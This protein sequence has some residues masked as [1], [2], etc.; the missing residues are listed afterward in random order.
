[1]LDKN[2]LTIV[3][4][5]QI[6]DIPQYLKNFD[7]VFPV[8]HGNNGE[9]GKLQGFLDL[10]GIKYVGSNCLSSALCMDKGFSKILFDYLKIPQLPYRIIDYK[11]KLKDILFPVIVKPC[12]SGSSIGINKASNYK[13]LK[14]A[15][16][17]A[18]KY[19]KKI[20]IE[21]YLRVRELEYSK[22]TTNSPS[23][24][25]EVIP[26]KDYY[27][28]EAKYHS[29]SKII[30]PAILPKKIEKK[31]KE[32]ADKIFSFFECKDL[33]RIDFFLVDDTLYINEI[34]T[35]P[36]FT[37][38]SMFPKLLISK[39]ID[40]KDLITSLIINNF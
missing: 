18:A 1:M 14:S 32:Y 4:N 29:N 11:D 10:F 28:Y 19:D 16:K 38:I 40:Y 26:S 20:V 39:K 30:I 24:I 17:Q 15:I 9:D 22:T 7:V 25:G 6:N 3:K 31:L 23:K 35:L 33:A 21:Q 27:D 34:N 13:E 2:W 37:E 12:N 8:T 36:G 5:N